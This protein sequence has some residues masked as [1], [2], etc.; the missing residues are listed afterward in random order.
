[1]VSAGLKKAKRENA[2][3]WAKTWNLEVA[4]GNQRPLGDELVLYRSEREWS[5]LGREHTLQASLGM[6]ALRLKRFEKGER[7]D[8]LIKLL[9]VGEGDTVIDGTFGLGCDAYVASR[10]VGPSGRVLAFEASKPLA[11]LGQAALELLERPRSGPIELYCSEASLGMQ[12]LEPRSVDAVMLDVMFH[13][14]H[15]SSQAFDGLRRY[16]DQAPL[17]K[18][19]L[20]AARRVARKNVLVKLGRFG[21]EADALGLRRVYT[22]RYSKAAWALY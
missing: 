9:E 4:F 11:Y 2:V 6:A 8:W 13:L 19:L 15:A 12:A 1:L 16:A 7:N 3:A 20:E 5:L 14:P 17:S 18:E 22:G 21:L 10:L